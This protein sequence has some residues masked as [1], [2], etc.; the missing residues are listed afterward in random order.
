MRLLVGL[1]TEIASAMAPE[2]PDC[3]DMI[4]GCSTIICMT[5]NVVTN[6]VAVVYGRLL[7]P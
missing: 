3:T 7:L 2:S 6:N 1:G 5:R 4:S